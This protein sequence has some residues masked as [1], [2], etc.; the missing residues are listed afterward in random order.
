MVLFG[1]DWIRLSGSG[2]NRSRSRMWGLAG[3]YNTRR[4]R[5]HWTSTSLERC[6]RFRHWEISRLGEWRTSQKCHIVSLEFIPK[7]LSQPGSA[8]FFAVFFDVVCMSS[9]FWIVRFS[10]MMRMTSSQA[11]PASGALACRTKRSDARALRHDPRHA[12]HVWVAFFSP[13]SALSGCQAE[14]QVIG[15]NLSAQKSKK[16]KRLKDTKS[17]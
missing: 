17:K 3:S 9:V 15:S 14:H 11:S 7:T 12:W 4:V 10:A 6:E 1:T 16:N 2:H 13:R 5:F 8:V